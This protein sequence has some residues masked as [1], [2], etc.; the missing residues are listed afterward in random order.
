MDCWTTFKRR[1]LCS[2]RC[3]CFYLDS[4]GLLHRFSSLEISVEFQELSIYE[5]CWLHL[6]VFIRGVLAG[7]TI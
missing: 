2:I 7:C 3:T 6:A 5:S 4:F 1:V